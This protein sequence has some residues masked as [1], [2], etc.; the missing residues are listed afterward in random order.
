MALV[1]SPATDIFSINLQ[2]DASSLASNA[3][4]R[5]FLSYDSGSTVSS[6]TFSSS[7]LSTVSTLDA[8]QMSGPPKSFS[9]TANNSGSV[10]Y[11]PNSASTLYGGTG[12]DTLVGGSLA[13]A[14]YIGAGKSTDTGGAGV[15]TFYLP[16]ATALRAS[17]G[18]GA[19]NAQGVTATQAVATITD[20]GNGSDIVNLGITDG[21]LKPTAA[22]LIVGNA[23]WSSSGFVNL[24]Q[25]TNNSVI[26]VDNTGN[27]T[28][29]T[30]TGNN[31]VDLS[32][33]TPTQIANL[34]TVPVLNSTTG[35]INPTSVGY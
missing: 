22:K 27:W 29:T 34:F 23:D 15:D 31:Q 1:I 20:F 11:A 33:R 7:L 6:T 3:N 16:S 13:D 4:Y 12:S 8:T 24:T 10:I 35:A 5:L 21:N 9:A 19:A 25:V 26:L 28:S 17:Q 2:T 32:P 14:M 30:S 18:Q